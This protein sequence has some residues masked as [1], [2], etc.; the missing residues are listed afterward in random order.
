[1]KNNIFMTSALLR[2]NTDIESTK[3]GSL[4]GSQLRNVIRPA[5]LQPPQA[6]TCPENPVV[7]LVT[8]K[9][10]HIQ[11]SE[12]DSYSSSENLADS[13]TAVKSSITEDISSSK[14]AR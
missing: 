5:I 13:K 1:K 14:T 7:S 2:R 12:D 6:L 4:P 10:A 11:L 8:K 9:Q 3:E